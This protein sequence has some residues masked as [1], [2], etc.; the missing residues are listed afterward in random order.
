MIS[1]RIA[2]LGGLNLPEPERVAD[3]LAAMKRLRAMLPMDGGD[4]R[5]DV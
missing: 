4:L 2:P 3:S 1:R 5:R